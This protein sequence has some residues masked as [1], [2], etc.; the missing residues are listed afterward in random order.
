VLIAQI[1]E[2]L[3]Q[4]FEGEVGLFLKIV[5]GE[6]ADAFLELRLD[7]LGEFVFTL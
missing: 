5:F 2:A 1:Q 7:G 6:H 4:I 3:L